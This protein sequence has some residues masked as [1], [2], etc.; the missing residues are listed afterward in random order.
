MRPVSLKLTGTN[1]ESA[2]VNVLV[3]AILTFSPTEM[4][5]K[6]ATYVQLVRSNAGLYVRESCGT[7]RRMLHET[8]P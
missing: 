3:D 5:G 8:Q 7:I 6:P 2:E 4:Y 1:H